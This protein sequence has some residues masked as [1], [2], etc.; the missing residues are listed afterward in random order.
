MSTPCGLVTAPSQ[1]LTGLPVGR[2][3]CRALCTA[4]G[5][6]F[7]EGQP[8]VVHAARPADRQQWDL[9]GIYCPGCRPT[10]SITL[11]VH[12]CRAQAWLAVQSLPAVREHRFALTGVAVE[13]YSPPAEGNRP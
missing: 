4:C 3:G 7:T 13:C 8:V 12:D 9:T 10:L 2:T 1:V 5:E 11:G 6:A